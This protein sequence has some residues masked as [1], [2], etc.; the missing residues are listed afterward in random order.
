VRI[1]ALL[2]HFGSAH[3][4]L[5][6]SP[7]ELMQVPCIGAQ[8]STTL[9][10]SLRS[11]DAE[12]EIERAQAAEV[13]LLAMGQPDYPASLATIPAAPRV[14]YVKGSI[15]AADER[16]VALVGTRHPTAYGKKVAK[17]LG[18]GLARA[19]VTVVSGLARGIDGIAHHGALDGGGRTL[20]ILAGGLSSIYPPEHRGLAD[21]VVVKGALVTESA[22]EQ[23][24]VQGLFPARNRIIS[25]L[26]RVVVIVQA[27][28]RSGAL[29]TASLAGEQGRTVMAVPGPV[30]VEASAG[31]NALIR[32]GAVLCRSVDDILEELDGVSAVARRHRDAQAKDTLPDGHP[33]GLDEMQSRIYE[34]LADGARSIDELAQ[35]LGLKVP[36]LA[37][38]L[39]ML[40]MRKVVRR[41]PGS[42]Y[43]RC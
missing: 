23:E 40:E 33:A 5:Q 1:A 27:P 32:D 34:A 31:C 36:E 3:R 24:P 29:I 22:M 21:R 39:L 8:V 19:G 38:T 13:R 28:A 12:A 11:V 4:V 9:S 30:D 20:A 16:A 15:L 2:E 25:G 35:G 6:A 37:G 7:A 18:E 17:S 14:L 42:R 41:L 43:E 26:S 10:A